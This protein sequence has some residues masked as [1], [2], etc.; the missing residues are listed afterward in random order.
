VT[1]TGVSRSGKERAVTVSGADLAKYILHRARK[2]CLIP[3]TML[4]AAIRAQ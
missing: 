2:G 3:G 1:V 4:P